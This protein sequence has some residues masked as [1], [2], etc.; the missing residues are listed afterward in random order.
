MSDAAEVMEEEYKGFG[1]IRTEQVDGNVYNLASPH[2]RHG[3]ICRHIFMA[4]ASALCGQ[5]RVSMENLDLK[6]HSGHPDESKRGD[7]VTPDIMIFCD[8]EQLRGNSYYGAPKFVAEV[9]SPSTAKRDRTVKFRIYE[10]AGASEYWI[11]SP[12]GTIDIYYL[13]DGHYELEQSIERS[14]DKDDEEYNEDMKIVLRCFPA[15]EMT[16]GQIFE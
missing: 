6:Y 5:C 1:K 3:D 2:Y 4:I 12:N 7:Y 15:I 10:Q 8:G 11:V 16:V 13:V 9:A 14:C